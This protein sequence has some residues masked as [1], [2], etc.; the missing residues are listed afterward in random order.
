MLPPGAATEGA[1]KAPISKDR[2]LKIKTVDAD[3]GKACDYKSR[4]LIPLSTSTMQI[5]SA[6]ITYDFR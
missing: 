6:W 3:Y 2:K 4:T 5:Y 1:M